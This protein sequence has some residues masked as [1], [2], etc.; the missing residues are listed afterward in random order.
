MARS[1]ELQAELELKAE[2]S[3]QRSLE[4][5]RTAYNNTK[6][7]MYVWEALGYLRGDEPVPTWIATYL[8]ECRRELMDLTFVSLSGPNNS[9]SDAIKKLPVALGFVREQNFNA[10]AARRQDNIASGVMLADMVDESNGADP[11]LL[12]GRRAQEAGVRKETIYKARE[13]AAKIWNK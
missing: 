1:P 10:I 8:M 12:A 9:A 13:R 2:A 6:N 3:R 5:R 7:P 4:N 11:K